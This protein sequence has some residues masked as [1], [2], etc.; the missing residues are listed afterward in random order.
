MWHIPREITPTLL[1]NEIWNY[2]SIF[3][4][5]TYWETYIYKCR[6]TVFSVTIY[7]KF[8]LFLSSESTEHFPSDFYVLLT[9]LRKA[10]MRLSLFSVSASSLCRPMAEISWVSWSSSIHSAAFLSAPSAVPF[11]LS[12]SSCL[13]SEIVIGKNWKIY[14]FSLSLNQAT[15]LQTSYIFKHTE[16]SVFPHAQHQHLLSNAW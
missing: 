11:I 10:W 6:Y 9:L 7:E 3:F 13:H 8:K 4:T 2:C 16:I 15:K 5:K 14:Y 1:S 12:S